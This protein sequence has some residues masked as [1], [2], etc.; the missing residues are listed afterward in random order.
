M[1]RVLTNAFL[2]SKG[3]SWTGN[4]LAIL[5]F[6]APNNYAIATL[7]DSSA[8]FKNEKVFAAG[9]PHESDQYTFSSGN[10]S[11]IAEKPLI[12]GY[13]IGFNNQTQQGMSGGPLLNEKGEVIGILGQGNVAIL[14]DEAIQAATKAIADYKMGI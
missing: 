3:D 8:A 2:R 14:D 12:G 5:E 9:F 7:G 6:Q 4:D 1:G 13:Q 11:L 10:I